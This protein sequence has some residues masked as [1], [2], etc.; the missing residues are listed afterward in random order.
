MIPATIYNF[1]SSPT[2][3]TPAT[4]PLPSSSHNPVLQSPTFTTLLA[5]ADLPPPGP[6]YFAAR[7]ALWTTPTA[8]SRF[9][10]TPSTS[11]VKLE[12]LLSQPAALESQE[13]WDAGLSKVWKGLVG[14]GRLKN[15]LPLPAV[16][17]ILYAG[18]RR[19]GTWPDNAT[20]MDDD[21]FFGT[22]ELK[23]SEYP[24]D[25]SSQ[26]SDTSSLMV[27]ND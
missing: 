27:E 21:N 19:D 6:E 15:L 1:L 18:W 16:V 5:H 14:G 7:R 24:A 17:K 4:P 11:R 3:S 12:S 22:I 25:R 26:M 8:N 2:K 20:V 23:T 9:D 13:I 10:Q